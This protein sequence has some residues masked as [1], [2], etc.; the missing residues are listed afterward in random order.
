MSKIFKC[1]KKKNDVEKE[2]VKEVST[3]SCS[4][5]GNPGEMMC[6]CKCE[7]ICEECEDDHAG[8]D[9]RKIMISEIAKTLPQMLQK[10]LTE[11]E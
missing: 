8:M 4:K 1:C 7:V 3:L 10:K 5:H 6:D 9:H 11:N 2:E